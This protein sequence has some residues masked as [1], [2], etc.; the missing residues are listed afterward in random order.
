MNAEEVFLSCSN[1]TMGQYRIIVLARGLTGAAGCVVSLAVLGI[2][3]FT[4]R[5]KAWENLPKRIYLTNVL[6][7]LLYSVVAIAAVNYSHPPSQE[8]TWCEAMGFLLHYTGTLVIIHY[9]AL[10]FVITFQVTVPVC[11]AVRKSRRGGNVRRSKLW[12]VLLF[13]LLFFCP[14]L[15]SWEPFLPQLP[16]YGNYGPLCW[17]RLELTDN[18]TTNNSNVLFLQTIPFAVVCFGYFV[19]SLTVTFTLCR[20][21]YKFRVTT[22][23]S[24]IIGVIP[25]VVAMTI[26]TFMLMLWFILSTIP[27]RSLSKI[28]SFSAWLRNVTVALASTIGILVIVGVYVHFPTHLCLQC[29]RALH[30]ERGHNEQQVIHLPKLVH[31]NH[32]AVIAPHAPVGDHPT[33]TTCNIPHSPVTTEC[34]CSPLIAHPLAGDQRK[35]PTHTMCNIPH[36]PVT[37]ECVCTPLIAHPPEVKYHKYP[38]HT[39]CSISHEL[40]TTTHN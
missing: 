14:L 37:T 21:Y 33:H 7:T 27:F 9:C 38:T 11:Q 34:M 16:S 18:C 26:M 35:Y 15:N 8:S 5:K 23:G 2:V 19:L 12:E 13:I 40:V 31:C 4:T 25:A 3:L 36:S 30:A 32:Q 20:M 22:I 39:T 10:T 29:R 24:R 6:Y 17:F 1:L 28:V